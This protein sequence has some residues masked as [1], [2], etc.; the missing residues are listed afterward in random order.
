MIW[1]PKLVTLVREKEWEGWER[2]VQFFQENKMVVTKSFF[3]LPNKHKHLLEHMEDSTRHRTLHSQKPIL[4][5]NKRYRNSITLIK[6]YPGIN[7]SNEYTSKI[8]IRIEKARNTSINIKQVLYS[9]SLSLKLKLW[10]LKCT[11]FLILL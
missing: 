11:V 6:S 2:L 7:E 5:I 1:L 8:W 9:Q 4:L 3:T 10:M